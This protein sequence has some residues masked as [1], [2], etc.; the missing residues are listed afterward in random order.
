MECEPLLILQILRISSVLK[1]STTIPVLSREEELFIL[2][3]GRPKDSSFV[4]DLKALEE[5]MHKSR[6][7][8]HFNQ[9]FL[10]HRRGVYSM[11]STGIS[12]GGGSKVWFFLYP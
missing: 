9:K 11:K 1:N 2:L 10:D 6:E 7:Q 3:A 4:Q 8:F 5:D 12:Y